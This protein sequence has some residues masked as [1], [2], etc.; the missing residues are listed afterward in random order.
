MNKALRAVLSTMPLFFSSCAGAP[1]SQPPEG[2]AA[3]ATPLP[4]VHAPRIDN[5]VL[6]TIDGVRWQE[7]FTGADPTRAD[8]AGL[9]HG[10]AR[11][12]RG[13]TPHL[14]RLFFDGGTVL[15]DPQLGERFLAS[16]PRYV[17]LPAYVEIMTGAAS[18]CAGNDCQPDVPWTIAAEV[19]RRGA[20]GGAAVFS[21][22]STVSRAVPDADRLHLEN[23]RRPGDLDP[24]Y[25]GH[26]DYRPDRRTAAAAITHLLRNR[27]RMLWVA[28][29]DTDEWAHRND[30][31]GYIESLRFADAFVG[32]LCAHLMD[33][34]SYGAG[35]TVL[36]TTDHGRDANF[37]DHGGPDSAAVWLMARGGHLPAK[38]RRGL[39]QPRYLR[40]IAPT[41]ASLYGLS[42]RRCDT[43]GDVL[44]DL[45]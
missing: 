42:H 41:I 8:E 33:M 9:P 3:R 12:A 18:G 32:E 34:G 20:R 21:S 11:T 10:E 6:V 26:G 1:P 5:V 19:A 7:I 24:P 44:S 22:W 37:T 43:C 31:R 4:A 16:G 2:T 36:V 15:G 38:G 29:G 23:G 14:H 35:T 39:A 25:P 40:D 30:Y 45:L 28:L 17:S 13:L 27:P